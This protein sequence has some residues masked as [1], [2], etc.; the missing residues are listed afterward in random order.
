MQCTDKLVL[1]RLQQQNMALSK[2]H[3]TEAIALRT[4]KRL[5]VFHKSKDKRQV[6]VRN[7][8]LAAL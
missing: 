1:L 4:P 6:R 7:L 2:L 5:K 3:P 8:V